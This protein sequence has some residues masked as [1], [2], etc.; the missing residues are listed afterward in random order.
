MTEKAFLMIPF[1][2]IFGFYVSCSDSSSTSCTADAAIGLI[3]RVAVI[4]DDC[5]IGLIGL[6]LQF[7]FFDYFLADLNVCRTSAERGTTL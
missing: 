5:T 4:T 7:G 2:V 1:T 3:T 6:D